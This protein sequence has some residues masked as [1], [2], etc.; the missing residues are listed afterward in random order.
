M[1]QGVYSPSFAGII[2]VLRDS[3]LAVSGVGTSTFT[4]SA[5]GYPNNFGGVVDALADL[6]TSISGLSA[7]GGGGSGTAYTA[8]S[9][10]YLVGAEFNVAY[11]DVYNNTASGGVQTAQA[12]ADTAQASGNAALG[13]GTTALASG[14]SALAL[15]TTA[16]ASG[17]AA[18]SVGSV[19]QASGNAALSL[20]STALASG[21]AALSVAN[22]ALASGNAALV[23]YVSPPTISGAHLTSLIASGTSENFTLDLGSI[24]VPLSVQLSGVSWL[25]LYTTSAART[26]DAGRTT[27]GG[28]LQEY[29]DL[30]ESAPLIEAANTTA[31]E[32]IRFVPTAAVSQADE[33]TGLVYGSITNYTSVSGVVY[34][35]FEA[36]RL[37]D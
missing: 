17:N 9:G 27:P 22:S 11:T 30:G 24:F 3:I 7:G 32:T 28:T 2:E 14:N 12:A 5:E 37:R 21:N 19:A 26:A 34:L 18:L 23:T 4:I 1:A 35:Y 31:Q 25:R 6:N 15:G 29:I 8:G 36:A 16:L 33:S 10:L 13:L 20:G